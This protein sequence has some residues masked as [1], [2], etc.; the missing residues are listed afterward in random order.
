[1]SKSPAIGI[2]NQDKDSARPRETSFSYRGFADLPPL[3]G[4]HTMSEAATIGLTV[5]ASVA[6]LKRVHWSLER[7]HQIFVSHITSE[8][9]YELKMAFSLHAYYCS[10]HVGEFA[11]RVREMRQPPYGLEMSPDPNL[12]L[13]FD[14]ILAA[15]GTPALL[16]GLYEYAVPALIR[17]IENLIADTNKLFDHPTFRISRLT[18]VEMRDIQQYGA[19]AVRCLVNTNTREELRSWLSTLDRMLAA[20]GDLDGKKEASGDAVPPVLLRCSL[21]I[22]SGPKTRR[23]L[24]GSLQH[25]RQR[26]GDAFRYQYP[27]I[28]QDHH[29]VLQA[30]A[31]DRR[32][33][34][35]GQHHSGNARQALAVLS[36]HDPS[37]MGRGASRDDGRDRICLYGNRLVHHSLEF[38]MVSWTQ[39][40]THRERASRSALYTIEQGLMARK[41]GKQYEWKVAVASA[42]ALTALIQDYDWADEI[43]H[44]KIGR[45]WIVS[46]IGSEVE[47]I[48]YGDKAWAKILV[49]WKKWKEDGLTEHR[50]WWPELYR[51]ACR[52][53]GVSIP[54]L[55]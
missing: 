44:A 51:V 17:A 36:R 13:F 22:R 47:A 21:R 19:E 1:M 4:L 37:A 29:A 16:L 6:R 48:A 52:R 45:H 18:I 14:E 28:S 46:E 49:D 15:P 9:I 33:R 54:I 27:A 8:P 50:N 40:H 24:S 10:E 7:L 5:S 31:R 43:L 23:T 35:D 38:H 26:G 39:Y 30:H 42:N 20:A 25:G 55:S 41:T 12:D 32:A 53:R 2:S 3:V 11:T 34:D